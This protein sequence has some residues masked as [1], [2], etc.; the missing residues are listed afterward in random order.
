MARI[1]SA[2]KKAL[3]YVEYAEELEQY[4]NASVAYSP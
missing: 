1:F 3:V 2:L 4:L